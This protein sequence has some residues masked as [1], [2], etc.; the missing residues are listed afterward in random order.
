MVAYWEWMAVVGFDVMVCHV[1]QGTFHFSQLVLTNYPWETISPSRQ[2]KNCDIG[3]LIHRRV[4]VFNSIHIREFKFRE[5]AEPQKLPK[6]NIFSTNYVDSID[7]KIRSMLRYIRLEGPIR[8]TKIIHTSGIYF[9]IETSIAIWEEKQ[10]YENKISE[11][12][13]FVESKFQHKSSF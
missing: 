8:Y 11:D 4:R 12:F 3:N 1:F 6:R 13:R 9:T 7:N 5:R 2:S 10:F